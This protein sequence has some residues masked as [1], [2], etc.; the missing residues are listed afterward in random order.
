MLMI[1]IIAFM[2]FFLQALQ[3]FERT[4]CP[5]IMKKTA[6]KFSKMLFDNL[7]WKFFK[8]WLVFSIRISYAKICKST[9]TFLLL[10]PCLYKKSQNQ[11]LSST[12]I[13]KFG[14]FLI[15]SYGNHLRLRYCWFKLRPRTKSQK[16]A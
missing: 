4:F 8:I 12:K 13:L 7:Y 6:S 11:S 16:C 15:K 9:Y 1:F 10:T 3:I 14:C 5:V 2:L